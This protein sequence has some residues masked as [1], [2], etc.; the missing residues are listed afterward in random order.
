MSEAD[1]PRRPN[2]GYGRPPVEHQFR[3]GVSGNPSGRPKR[4]QGRKPT[5]T[6]QFGSQPANQILMEEAYRM[7]TLREG[8][9]LITLPAIQAVFRAMGVSALKG[10]RFAQR[11]L[12]ELVQQVENSDRE[13]RSAHLE[14]MMEYKCGWEKAIE[15][16]EARGVPPPNPVPHPDDIIIDFITPGASVCGPMTKEDK[17][18]WDRMLDCRDDLQLSVSEMAAAHAR[19]RNPTKKTF[20]LEQWKLEQRF[21]DKLNDNL[22]KRY[23]KQLKDRCWKEGASRPGSQK[24]RAW[25][26]E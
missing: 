10:N 4:A 1:P 14:A 8:D 5:D 12:A 2:V 18:A 15:E 3:K 23:R 9:Q 20:W 11:T 21:Y 17:V 25:P 16:A 24:K 22:P 6:L 19:A 13:L 7:V 26:G